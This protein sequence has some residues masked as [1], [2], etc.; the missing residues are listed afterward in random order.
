[1][2][3]FIIY[4]L[5]RLCGL[6]KLSYPLLAWGLS[7]NYGQVAAEAGVTKRLKRTGPSTMANS[8]GWQLM[9]SVGWEQLHAFR[10]Y[11]T[12]D[13]RVLL[14]ECSWILRA[15]QEE[16]FLEIQTWKQQNSMV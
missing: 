8:L 11:S 2:Y 14:G 9:L 5:S 3:L 13:L 15:S 1:M 12:G 6:I 10:L 16:A 7:H 4:Y